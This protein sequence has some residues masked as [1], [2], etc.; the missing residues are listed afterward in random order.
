M[1]GFRL[2]SLEKIKARTFIGPGFFVLPGCPGSQR[3][4]G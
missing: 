3:R 4:A 2:H 1:N